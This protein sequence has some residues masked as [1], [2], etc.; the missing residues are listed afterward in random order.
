MG[1]TP[2]NWKKYFFIETEGL[3]TLYERLILHSFFRKFIVKYRIKKA[4]ECPSFGITGI[5]GINSLYLANY[6]IE[7]YICDNN[8]ERLKWIRRL[9]NKIG[10]KAKFIV[11]EDYSNLPIRD[12][13]FD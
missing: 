7:V 10:L 8:A 1:I 3:G 4:I 12:N 11:I 9:W 6:G 5:S 13:E 2:K